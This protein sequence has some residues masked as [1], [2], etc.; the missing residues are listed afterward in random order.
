MANEFAEMENR[1][2]RNQIIAALDQLET[3]VCKNYAAI[4]AIN[5]GMD[6][7]GRDVVIPMLAEKDIGRRLLESFLVYATARAAL[8]LQDREP[9]GEN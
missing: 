3:T 2:T 4:Q 7:L 6:E 5:K 1:K 9:E 8:L